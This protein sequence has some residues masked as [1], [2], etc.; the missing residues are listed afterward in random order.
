M[1]LQPPPANHVY[2]SFPE[3]LQAVNTH[4][5]NEGYA[6]IIKQSKKS[7]KQELQ[8]VWLECNKSDQCKVKGFG[9][10]Q[11]SSQRDDC[12]FKIIA[13]R[14]SKLETW[15]IDTKCSERNYPPTL[16]GAHPTH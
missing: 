9:I 11:S 2:A 7:K 6:V 13:N 16:V 4:A 10:R 1:D 3:L 14:S 15:T 8:N 12:P 5:A